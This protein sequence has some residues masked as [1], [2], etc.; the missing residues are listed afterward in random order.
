MF[1]LTHV[2]WGYFG[3][4]INGKLEDVEVVE[5]TEVVESP[6]EA[7]GVLVGFAQ[8]LSSSGKAFQDILTMI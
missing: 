6:I 8:V 1:Q 3:L 2:H 5:L 7:D 4:L